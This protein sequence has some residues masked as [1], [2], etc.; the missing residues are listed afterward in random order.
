ELQL[1]DGTTADA[2]VDDNSVALKIDGA[3][4]ATTKAREGSVVRVTYLPAG[5]QIPLEQHTAELTFKDAAGNTVNRQWTFR[6]LKNIVLP[7]P[8]I[9]ETFDSYPEDTQPPGW[10]ATNFTAHNSDGRDI[11]DQKSESYENWV[12]V[13]VTH[14]GLIDEPSLFNIT[15]GQFI[16]I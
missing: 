4:V 3:S 6:N 1:E 2:K 10:V 11:T 15:P 9:L 14:I 5:L 16:E 7:T 8:K 13:D 12:L